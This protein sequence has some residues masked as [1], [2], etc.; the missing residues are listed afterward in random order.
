[1][2][3]KALSLTERAQSF[4]LVVIF[5]CFKLF[6][7]LDSP[8]SD[9]RTSNAPD[10]DS[11]VSD[12]RTS[13]AP[14]LAPVLQIISVLLILSLLLQ[15]ANLQL[16]IMYLIVLHNSNKNNNVEVEFKKEFP[17]NKFLDN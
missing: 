10:Q 1:M 3:H 9:E 8:V 11:P 5:I 2:S 15:T 12:E 6:L 7:L 4:S 17:A 13:N 14:D 16:I